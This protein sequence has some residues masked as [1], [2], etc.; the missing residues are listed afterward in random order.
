VRVTKVA[1]KDVAVTQGGGF[2][3]ADVQIDEGGPTV[4]E[5]EA[6]QMPAG[7]VVE[8][9]LFSEGGTDQVVLS[10]PLTADPQHPDVRSRLRSPSPPG[11]REVSRESGGAD[12]HT[13]D[14]RI[15]DDFR[16]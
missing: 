2:A 9:H 1:G 10:L 13:A 6:H 15:G 4:V 8:L 3:V 12:R 16:R 11:S 14:P 5:V 7:T